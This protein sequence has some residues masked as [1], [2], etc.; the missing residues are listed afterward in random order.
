MNKVLNYSR[1]IDWFSVMIYSNEFNE[2]WHY[3]WRSFNLPRK[4]LI[5][6][7]L[8]MLGISNAESYL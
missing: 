8:Y 1:L 4:F 6:L 5:M 2:L 3:A 7:M